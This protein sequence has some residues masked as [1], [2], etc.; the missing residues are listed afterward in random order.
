MATVRAN[1]IVPTDIPF[2]VSG[3]WD[4]DNVS[5][6][7][8]STGIDKRDGEECI[9]DGCGY[10]IPDCL[11]HCHIVG[12]NDHKTVC[13]PSTPFPIRLSNLFHLVGYASKNQ[14]YSSN[15]QTKCIELLQKWSFDVQ[16]SSLLIRFPLFF[17]QISDGRNFLF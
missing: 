11:D 7:A 6:S 3:F 1:L 8:F 16:V 17:P 2:D 13:P 12:R 4:D 9:I 10:N 14:I 15:Q 5:V